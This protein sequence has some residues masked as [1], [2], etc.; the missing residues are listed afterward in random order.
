MSFWLDKLLV[1]LN[2]PKEK[3]RKINVQFVN[4]SSSSQDEFALNILACSNLE[5]RRGPEQESGGET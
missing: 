3:K 2:Q 5:I 1:R 4:E